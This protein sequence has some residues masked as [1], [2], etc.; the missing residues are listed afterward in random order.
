M[1]LN[2]F[3]VVS[4]Q[5]TNI[6]ALRRGRII[7]AFPTCTVGCVGHPVPGGSEL[8]VIDLVANLIVRIVS[9]FLSSHNLKVI[10]EISDFRLTSTS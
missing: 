1:H 4:C 7:M 6:N 5:L 8:V 2:Q 3:P 9:T 10:S